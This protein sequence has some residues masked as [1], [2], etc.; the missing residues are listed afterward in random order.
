MSAYTVLHT[1]ILGEFIQTKI[2][3]HKNL[4]PVLWDP[5]IRAILW[6]PD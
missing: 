1:L 2:I 4:R 5:V 6:L 3:I